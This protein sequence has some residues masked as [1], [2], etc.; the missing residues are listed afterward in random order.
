MKQH[1]APIAGMADENHQWYGLQFHPEVTHTIQGASILQ[2][3]VVD[4]CKAKTDWTANNIID[5][6]IVRIREQVGEK[7]SCLVFQAGLILPSLQ[8]CCIVPLAIQLICVFVDTGLLR[9]NEVRT[10]YDYVQSAFGITHNCSK[11]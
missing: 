7:R 10:S 2:R 6:A 4:I 11:C 1:N 9:L 8:P 3:F 5:Q